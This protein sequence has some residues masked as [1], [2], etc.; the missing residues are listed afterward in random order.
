L[1][2]VLIE[3]AGD[4]LFN[5]RA[6]VDLGADLD[7]TDPLQIEALQSLGDDA[8]VMPRDA[9]SDIFFSDTLAINQVNGS[10]L[11]IVPLQT[12]Q[13]FD[14]RD[15]YFGLSVLQSNGFRY[16]GIG[17]LDLFGELGLI[18]SSAAGLSANA[19]QNGR[20]RFNNCLVGDPNSCSALTQA[21]VLRLVDLSPERVFVLDEDQIEQLFLSFGNE[22]L[23]GLPSVFSTDISNEDD[24]E[25][26]EDAT[27]SDQTEG[28]QVSSLE[29]Q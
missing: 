16:T 8:Y 29:A 5:L 7:L 26:E 27:N 4:V 24:D 21:N 17:T 6:E 25:D 28:E 14:T 11:I 2:E 13:G 10:T 12:E 9:R 1:G 3:N 15:E 20:T 23:W 19:Q 22:E 18:R